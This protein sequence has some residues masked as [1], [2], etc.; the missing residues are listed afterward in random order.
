MV[1]RLWLWIVA[2]VAVIGGACVPAGSA[3]ADTNGAGPVWIIGMAGVTWADVSEARTPNLAGLLAS[4]SVANVST[5]ALANGTCPVAGWLTLSAGE[6]AA[7]PDGCTDAYTKSAGAAAVTGNKESAFHA[8]LGRLVGAAENARLVGGLAPWLAAGD[9]S[10]AGGRVTVADS[11]G[12]NA[13]IP[14][15]SGLAEALG[16]ASEQLVV[17]DAGTVT[18]PGSAAVPEDI[19]SATAEESAGAQASPSVTPPSVSEATGAGSG[20]TA[21]SGSE[22]ASSEASVRSSAASA[23]EKQLAAVDANVGAALAAAPGNATVLV[24]T[25]A[26][27]GQERLG[28]FAMSGQAGLARSTT[29]RTAGLVTLT[30]VTAA[31]QAG[32]TGGSSPIAATG[33]TST[34]AAL[35]DADVHAALLHGSYS[36]L[37]AA[38]G[39]LAVGIVLWGI[40]RIVR[41]E[42]GDGRQGWVQL[43]VFASAVPIAML[44]VNLAGWWRFSRS[45]LGLWAGVAFIA[46][47]IGLVGLM[48]ARPAHWVAAPVVRIGAVTAPAIGLDALVA[49]AS[50][51]PGLIITAV[52]GAQPTVGGRFYGVSNLVFAL[53]AA[54][55]MVAAG[56]LAEWIASGS[57]GSRV[58][59]RAGALA[60]ATDNAG[61]VGDSDG[62]AV[63]D[64]G[65]AVG[66]E[67]HAAQAGTNGGDS[68]RRRRL[69]GWVVIALGVVTVL[70]D[71][72][73]QIGADFGGPLPLVIGFGLLALY[74]WRIPLNW[75][76]CAVVA[77]AGVASVVL[78]MLTDRGGSSHVGQ[79]GTEVASGNSGALATILRKL[80]A[81]MF[82]APWPWALLIAVVI[83]AAIVVAGAWVSRHVDF[84][85]R[86]PELLMWERPEIR[87]GVSAAA[88]ALLVASFTNDSGF[89][90]LAM[91]M[92]IILPALFACVEREAVLM[93]QRA[94]L[95]PRRR[96]AR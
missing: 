88:V 33:Q 30:D 68:V 83:L 57:L 51:R 95:R 7:A 29:T 20:A 91:G 37:Y 49:G 78:F 84:S 81:A 74:T 93:S 42:F 1:K 47:I 64:A 10:A 25:V 13:P 52:Q 46:A 85:R 28:V 62:P 48:K 59:A 79:F 55:S 9:L 77:L 16:G 71:G 43:A 66:S 11:A 14:T 21:S 22:R 23:R 73:P 36:A 86:T 50:G 44:L 80:E 70:I 8:Q 56:A 58:G 40:A 92:S 63:G 31:A 76:R 96:T 6:R 65:N 5:R 90:I 15:D 41:R 38:W 34:R 35:V 53:F 4:M 24:V 32:L 19:R 12:L 67:G 69:A 75:W 82:G 45:A 72:L 94:A 39:I 87:G 54:G 26:G 89:M 3:R 18:T 60:G 27:V 2:L 17:A 61:G